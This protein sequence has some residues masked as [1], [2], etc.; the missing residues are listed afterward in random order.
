MGSPLKIRMRDV[1]QRQSL[2][3][4]EMPPAVEY[5]EEENKE[6]KTT[7]PFL[8]RKTIAVKPAKINWQTKSKIDC[9]NNNPVLSNI[10]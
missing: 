4:Q 5:Y 8:K 3:P 2:K 6:K 10:L 9:W 1:S 7:K